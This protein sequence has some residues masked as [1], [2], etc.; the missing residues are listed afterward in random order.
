[1]GSPGAGKTTLLLELAKQLVYEAEQS[2]TAPIPVVLNLAVWRPNHESFADWLVD[3]LFLR[4]G[5]VHR[6]GQVL[7]DS[8]SVVPLLDGL[9]E[10]ALENRDA[11]VAAI[12]AFRNAHDQM[13]LVICSRVGEYEVLRVRLRLRAAIVIEPLT[14]ADVDDFLLQAGAEM[15]AL[16]DAL[17]DNE[18]LAELVT[19][20]LLLNIVVTTYLERI[21]IS[22]LAKGGPDELR[23]AVL[24]DYVDVMLERPRAVATPD[25]YSFN[26]VV[27]W[28]RW[29]AQAM[30]ARNLTVF[31]V[32]WIQ[33][34]WLAG[35]VDRW[36]VTAGIAIS[37]GLWSGL[38]VGLLFWLGG[39]FTVGLIGAL[40]G[41]LSVGL[42]GYERDISP[43]KQVRW[44]SDGLRSNVPLSLLPG[45]SVG[46]TI[47]FG[48]MLGAKG[49]E[50]GPWNDMSARV[51]IGLTAGL[52]GALLTVVGT[53]LTAALDTS[54]QSPG[55]A[56]QR[57]GRNGLTSG[58]LIG[59]L[60]S[61]PFGL[62]SALVF[63][64]MSGIV[65]GLGAGLVFGLMT[66]LRRG[67][68]AYIRH[69]ALKWVLARNG[70][71]P[72]DLGKFL[73]FAA[74]LTMLSRH[75]G[76]YTFIHRLVLEHFAALDI[77]AG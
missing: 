72:R 7:V 17:R 42:S 4:Y 66:G 32:D 14:R 45:L 54:V 5:V 76:G 34:D 24:S 3:E 27:V 48:V 36:L 55:N 11:C 61:L 21:D 51:A 64:I 52:I 18:Q 47:G 77:H 60:F 67:G 56:I 75:G 1:M 15:N 69:Q 29:L 10:V 16:R 30:L 74:R 39:G 20:P 33:P 46:L 38:C 43:A 8:Q 22:A 2:V 50:P 63:G 53:G 40:V 13:P 28:L 41:G 37:V 71:T 68:G 31:Y 70:S 62:L 65:F 25:T 49:L 9:D 19:N 73:E 6:L 58:L 59:S 35:R 26:R 57:S 44:S 12:N 23:Q